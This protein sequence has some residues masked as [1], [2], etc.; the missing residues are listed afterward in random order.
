MR[1]VR[2]SVM[3]YD[4]YDFTLSIELYYLSQMGISY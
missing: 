2:K 1:I 4:M 3:N